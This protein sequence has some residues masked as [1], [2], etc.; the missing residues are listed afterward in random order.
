MPVY[1]NK[2]DTPDEN[3]VDPLPGST[4]ENIDNSADG[5]DT[6]PV[7]VVTEHEIT[8]TET[9]TTNAPWV[10][11]TA[12]DDPDVRYDVSGMRMHCDYYRRI[13]GKD[14]LTDVVNSYT[15]APFQQ[16]LLFKNY[17]L[18]VQSDLQGGEGEAVVVDAFVPTIGDHIVTD[19]GDGR[20]TLLKVESVDV[21]SIL[22][23][24]RAHRITYRVISITDEEFGDLQSKVAQTLYYDERL[25]RHTRKSAL[26]S[27]E[28][29]EFR[30][31]LEQ[32]TNLENEWLSTF[33]DRETQTC[34]YLDATAKVY[35][36]LVVDFVQ[37]TFEVRL[38]DIR[39]YYDF[40]VDSIYKA[41]VERRRPTITQT[42]SAQLIT[43]DSLN[44]IPRL[45][46]INYTTITHAVLVD[47]SQEIGLRHWG[48]TQQTTKI[49]IA[50]MFTASTPTTP[51]LTLPNITSVTGH[52]FDLDWV[53]ATEHSVLEDTLMEWLTH[54][55]LSESKL[56]VLLSRYH[57]MSLSEQ[58]CYGP[59]IFFLARAKGKQ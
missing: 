59:I 15:P 6:T 52:L 21:T 39:R 55:P 32:M 26:T 40:E 25:S 57:E 19:I 51:Q 53:K 11:T 20:I 49:A 48:V 4:E 16:Y 9:V 37:R 17:T 38:P 34:V 18:F 54:T 12:S 46:G 27:D 47:S 10:E 7:T 36:P 1:K 22:S 35:H 42:E 24:A 58:Y 30:Q 31:H 33:Y 14:D 50:E 8:T 45:N 23:V 44:A 28:L 29:V 13:L 56:N 5:T 2:S 41:I 3:L 43:L